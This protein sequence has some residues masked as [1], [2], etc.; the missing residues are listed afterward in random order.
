MEEIKLSIMVTTY[1]LEKFVGETLD[2]VLNQK[3]D[4]SYE[5]LV[6]DDGSSDGTVDVIKE[7]ITLL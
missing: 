2:S 3:T 7:Y 4:Y 5:I 6:G 1:N